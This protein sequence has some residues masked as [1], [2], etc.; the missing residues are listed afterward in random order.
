MSIINDI[1]N[2]IEDPIPANHV[3]LLKRIIRRPNPNKPIPDHICAQWHPTKNGRWKP[4]DF[5]R[6]SNY[7]ATWYCGNREPCGCYHIWNAPISNRTA[8]KP[9]GCPWCAEQK[10]CVHMMNDIFSLEAKFPEIALEWHPTK[11]G[12]L[13][14]NQITA[15]SNEPT[16]W[17]C[18][19]KCKDGCLHEYQTTVS[20][21]TQNGQGC[22]FSGCCSPSKNVVFIHHCKQHIQKLL[23]IGIQRIIKRK[24]GLLYYQNKLHMDLIIW[25]IGNVLKNVLKDVCTYGKQPLQVQ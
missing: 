9:R 5:S 1:I 13:Q 21:R 7:E 2:D 17:L 24:M 20:N 3:S 12:D 11:N 8:K 18:P 16:W 19:N 10:R 22:P 15:Y 25:R 4:T 6:G 23:S 14:P